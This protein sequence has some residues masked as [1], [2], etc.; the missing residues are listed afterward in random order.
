MEAPDPGLA[1]KHAWQGQ[2]AELQQGQSEYATKNRGVQ[3][4]VEQMSE[5]KP[6]GGCGREFRIAATNPA[7]R[8]ENERNSQHNRGSRKVHA[9]GVKVHPGDQRQQEE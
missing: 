4:I 9:D 2:P 3:Q 1:R 8:K 5:T 6:Q 7:L